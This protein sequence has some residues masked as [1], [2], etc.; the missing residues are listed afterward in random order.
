MLD[1]D[2][3]ALIRSLRH[4]EPVSSFRTTFAYTN[5]THLLASR[6]VAKA[7]G[8]ADW[9]MVL[10]QE[11]LDP[12]GMKD[13]S[14]TVEAIEAA[15][16]H[17]NGPPLDTGGHDRGAFHPNLPLPLGWGRRHQLDR[18]GHGA[19]GPLAARQRHL[20][21][22]PHRLARESRRYAHAKGGSQRPDCPTPWVGIIYADAEWQHRLARWRRAELRLLCRHGA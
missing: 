8:A 17:A 1:F 11:L 3:A 5:I 22:A 15:A 4:V 10:R 12:L 20:R 2:E 16:N 21:G 18:R 9:N 13:S 7:A 19:L 6:I 14:Y